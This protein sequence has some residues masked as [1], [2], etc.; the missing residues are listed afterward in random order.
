MT[1]E[2]ISELRRHQ[3]NQDMIK[4]ATPGNRDAIREEFDEILR[5][6]RQ[7]NVLRPASDKFRPARRSTP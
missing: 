4:D 5:K 7:V 2:P 6:Q 1:Y 3:L